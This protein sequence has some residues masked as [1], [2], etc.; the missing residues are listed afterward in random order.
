MPVRCRWTSNDRLGNA[1][2]GLAFGGG[3]L[4]TICGHLDVARD[5]SEC[6]RRNLCRGERRDHSSQNSAIGGTGGLT[7][8]GAGTLALAGVNTY[9]GGT[10]INDGTL[11]VAS[12]DRLGDASGSADVRRRHVD[13]DLSVPQCRARRR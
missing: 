10:T 6:G 12:N 5:D 7:K 9:Q 11:L 1:N 8:T 3:T 13:G 4:R 2:G